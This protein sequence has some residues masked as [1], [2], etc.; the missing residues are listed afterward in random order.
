MGVGTP[1]LIGEIIA[2][3][4]CG[5]LALIDEA[6]RRRECEMCIWNGNRLCFVCDCGS[7]CYAPLCFV[8]CFWLSFFLSV[9]LSSD[10]PN[11]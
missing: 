10:D 6:L 7:N 1:V 4:L 5:L 3:S 8:I 2:L 11:E 9:C